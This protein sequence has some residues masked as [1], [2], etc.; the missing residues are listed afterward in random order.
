M[1]VL[2][3]D[4]SDDHM[5]SRAVVD[6]PRHDL[7]V[8]RLPSGESNIFQGDLEKAMCFGGVHKIVAKRVFLHLR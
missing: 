2:K 7:L 4:L 5:S 6:P 8:E 1:L 3:L